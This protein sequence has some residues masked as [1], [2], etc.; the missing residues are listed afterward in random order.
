MMFSTGH[1][2]WKSDKR[3]TRTIT[4]KALCLFGLK[5]ICMTYHCQLPS[6]VPPSAAGDRGTSKVWDRVFDFK[7]QRK[8]LLWHWVARP[9]LWVI[10]V[11]YQWSWAL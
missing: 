7:V 2:R 5:I 10:E 11:S 8:V 9:A 6:L 4:Q 1:S 3:G